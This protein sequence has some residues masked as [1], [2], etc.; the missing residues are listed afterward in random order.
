MTEELRRARVEAEASQ[1]SCSIEENI[2]DDDNPMVLFEEKCP[3]GGNG[4]VIFYTTTL[5]GIRKTF[6]D[7]NKI[8]FLLQ[9]FKVVYSE[10]DISS[11]S[12]SR[13]SYGVLW[14]GK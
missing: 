3:P 9:S 10:R 2:D 11:T 13:M 12:S 4:T 7:C 14:M 6:E 8:R 5:T 1:K